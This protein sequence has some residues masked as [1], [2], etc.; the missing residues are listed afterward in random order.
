MVSSDLI[1]IIKELL[2]L[3]G[4]LRRT[5]SGVYD[6]NRTFLLHNDLELSYDSSFLTN[7]LV[8]SFG[9]LV[10]VVTVSILWTQDQC[11]GG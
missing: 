10:L 7:D 11:R 9:V 8:S 4:S 1:S 3:P 2:S 6:G 5:G